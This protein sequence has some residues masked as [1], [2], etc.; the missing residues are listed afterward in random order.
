MKH[1][2]TGLNDMGRLL[3]EATEQFMLHLENKEGQAINIAE[4]F[5]LYVCNV[6]ASLVTTNSC[7]AEYDKFCAK[8]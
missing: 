7:L 4:E 6:I 2:G 3:S 1:Y 5:S 8:Y